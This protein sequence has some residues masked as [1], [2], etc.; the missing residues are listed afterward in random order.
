MQ[1][2]VQSYG[3]GTIIQITA[4]GEE[5]EAALDEAIDK[6]GEIDDLM[7]YFKENS[8]ISRIN[9][10]AGVHYQNVSKETYEVI[11]KAVYYSKISNGAI[12]ITIRPVLDLWNIGSK[13]AKVPDKD[14]IIENLKLVNYNDIE[15]ADDYKAIRLANEKQKIDVNCIAKGFAADEV[16]KVLVRH[17]IKN[18]M[19]N[20]GGNVYGHGS[21]MDGSMWRVGVQH[22]LKPRGNYVGI[23]SVKDKSVVTSGDY[24]KYFMHNGKKY[25][26]T[27]DTK[28]GY[29]IDNN[30][31][32]TTIVSDYS[33]DGDALTT[34]L[35][36]MGVEEG[37]N[38]A[39][40]IKGIEAII[41]TE[42]KKVYITDGLKDNFNLTDSEFVLE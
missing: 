24:E 36:G 15:F 34:C 35:Y 33:I 8:D 40:S 28:T 4:Y 39:K 27:I 5:A 21:K 6:I 42:D 22:P 30:I 18:A 1:K 7:S 11:K 12:D 20:L 3:L 31:V 26:H 17:G 38:F 25:H 41:V 9:S 10:T 2:S 23:L 37:L 32:S 14:D 19:I 13:D 16:K 29:P